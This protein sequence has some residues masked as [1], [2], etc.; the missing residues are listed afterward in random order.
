MDLKEMGLESVDCIDMML[1]S[2]K[3]R[4]FVNVVLNFWVP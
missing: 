3:W 1:H 2:D 4:A